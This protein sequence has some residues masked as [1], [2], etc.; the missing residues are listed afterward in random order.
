MR[1]SALHV[2]QVA[3]QHGQIPEVAG[4]ARQPHGL[5]QLRRRSRQIAALQS[6]R[7]DELGSSGFIPRESKSS[8]EFAHCL[9]VRLCAFDIALKLAEQRL[10]TV[11]SQQELFVADLAGDGNALIKTLLCAR[12]VAA[13]R[14]G[15]SS[16]MECT[17]AYL[18]SPFGAGHPQRAL[19]PFLR[20]DPVVVQ[21]PGPPQSADQTK[22]DVR[23]ARL[24]GPTQG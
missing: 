9:D 19:E 15:G 4:C 1:H 17:R 2:T 3:Q 13:K 11:T 6:E 24:Q 23:V 16:R 21:Q 20:F 12:I 18:C 22:C 14:R 7:C 10:R 5:A 8:A